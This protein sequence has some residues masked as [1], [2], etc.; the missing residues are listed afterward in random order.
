MHLSDILDAKANGSISHRVMFIN[1]AIERDESEQHFRLYRDG[2]IR[3]TYLLIAQED[4]VG[5][6]YKW[7]D[8]ELATVGFIGQE[9]FRIG[10]K[11]GATVEVVMIESHRLGET[12][13]GDE[14]Q[15][16]PRLL[17]VCRNT[18]GCSTGCCTEGTGGCYCDKCCIA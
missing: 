1:G 11:A 4:V 5:E 8:A 7:S 18:S 12:L 17:G 10:V 14:A 3:T 9:R 6:L 15:S 16:G 2:G 13:A